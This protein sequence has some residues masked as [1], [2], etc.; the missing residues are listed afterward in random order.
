MVHQSFN[1]NDVSFDF[2]SEVAA[3]RDRPPDYESHVKVSF[4]TA[5]IR[6]DVLEYS[7]STDIAEPHELEVDSDVKD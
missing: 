4:R 2:W 7:S 5:N 6:C 3:F 1:A